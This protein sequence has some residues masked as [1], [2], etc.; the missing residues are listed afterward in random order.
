[1][2]QDWRFRSLMMVVILIFI[3]NSCFASN[4]DSGINS[5]KD[6]NDSSKVSLGDAKD[7]LMPKAIWE[8]FY[9]LTK[10]PRPSHGEEQIS[11]Y[12]ANF[13]K[14][15]ALETTVDEVGNVLIRKPAT[16]GME[17]RKGLI[18]QAHMDMVAQKDA[19]KDFDFQT[20]PI[21]AYIEDRWV[22][23]NGTRSEERRVG[24]E[25]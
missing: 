3:T 4:I 23:A 6:N 20:D 17:N 5:T 10:V 9:N 12:L 24:K 22:K 7:F 2:K 16:P 1:M 18:L 11:A 25:C 13:G 15:L 14:E 19:D 21:Q 8:N